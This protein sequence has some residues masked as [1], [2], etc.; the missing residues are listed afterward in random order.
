M[1]INQRA[2]FFSFVEDLDNVLITVLKK[3]FLNT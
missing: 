1:K 3:Q 2:Y